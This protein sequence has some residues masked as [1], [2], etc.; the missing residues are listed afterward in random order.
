MPSRIKFSYVLEAKV[1]M[2][3]SG[4]PFFVGTF[5]Y[6]TGLDMIIKVIKEKEWR[7][8]FKKTKKITTTYTAWTLSPNLNKVTI[9]PFLE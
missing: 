6:I 1:K 2:E 9:K 8:R 4:K 3:A 7:L 5:Y